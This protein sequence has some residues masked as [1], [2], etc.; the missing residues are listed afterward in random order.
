MILLK[1]I[2]IVTS[3]YSVVVPVVLLRTR[4]HAI[5]PN[6]ITDFDIP[7]VSK[8]R[9]MNWLSKKMY[10]VGS[11]KLDDENMSD[12]GSKVSLSK[13]DGRTGSVILVTGGAGFLGQ[14]IVKL[15]EERAEGVK[16]IRVLDAK[17]YRNKL[18]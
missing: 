18:G 9:W 13:V 10:C 14:H 15:L 2:I 5:S 1:V 17:M 11:V 12:T 8:S 7:P 3:S 16:E 4:L 6:D